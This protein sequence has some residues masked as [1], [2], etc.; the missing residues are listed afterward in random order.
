MKT[1]LLTLVSTL[2]ASSAFADRGHHRGWWRHAARPVVYTPPPPVV[3]VPPAPRSQGHY[4]RRTTQHWVAGD[5]YQV[6][7]P[8]RC[9]AACRGRP[10]W[11]SPGRYETRQSPGRYETAESWVWVPNYAPLPGQYAPPPPQ[12]GYGLSTP[13]VGAQL[14]IEI[15]GNDSDAD[16]DIDINFRGSIN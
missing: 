2:V 5:S 11:C 14:N 7:V 15:D 12:Y 6:W 9:E 8:G 13:E 10:G 4:E 16:G 3:P 1:L